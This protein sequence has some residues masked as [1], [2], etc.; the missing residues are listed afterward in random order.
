M[1]TAV[2]TTVVA[3]AVV[4]LGLWLTAPTAASAKGKIKSKSC[5]SAEMALLTT[6]QGDSD[7]DG[8][9]DC[10]EGKQL[11][12]N[13]NDPDTDHDGVSDGDEVAEHCD[14]HDADSDHDGVE[15]GD[16]DS[17]G[18]PQQQ[19]KAFLDALTCPQVG[20]PGSIT[21][22]G[23]TALLDDTT[24]FEDTTCDALLAQLQTPG[25]V[26]KVEIKIV[27]DSLGALTATEVETEHDGDDD[28]SH[29]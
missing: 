28:H 29:D 18:M 14:P 6:G 21:A 7:G 17:P 24:E 10:R 19:M 23:T 25:T 22:L 9:S 1:R 5:A 26:V 11:G 3:V 8:L 27:E 13:P 16:D 15:D 12:T 20:V 2:K 4:A